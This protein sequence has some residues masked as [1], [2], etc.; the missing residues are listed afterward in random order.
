MNAEDGLVLSITYTIAAIDLRVALASASVFGILLSCLTFI[1][2]EKLNASAFRLGTKMFG[3]DL[4]HFNVSST[5]QLRIVAIASLVF[6]A[7][8]L[9]AVLF[10]F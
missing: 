8:F 6:Y 1:Y 3:K 4:K 5:K 9:F 2:A 7:M 10:V